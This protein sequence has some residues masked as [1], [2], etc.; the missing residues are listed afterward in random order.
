LGGIKLEGD[1]GDTLIRY[2]TEPTANIARLSSGAGAEVMMSVNPH[3]AIAD[4]DFRLVPDQDA[5]EV[6]ERLVE[7]AA[8]FGEAIAVDRIGSMPPARTPVSHPFVSMVRQVA[9]SV[10]GKEALLEP[11]SPTVGSRSVLGWSGMP[12]VGHGVAYA[13]SNIQAVN[14]HVRL[15][16]VTQAMQFVAAVMKQMGDIQ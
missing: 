6:F 7:I 15:E 5:D 4:M 11:L 16:H 3:E 1:F 13:G 2:Y 12:V 8:E 14:E 10:Y 9:L